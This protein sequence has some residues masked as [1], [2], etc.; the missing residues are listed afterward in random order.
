MSN[1]KWTST[2]N[3]E[4]EDWSGYVGV[5]KRH[6]YDGYCTSFSCYGNNVGRGVIKAREDGPYKCPDCGYA[7]VY[8]KRKMSKAVVD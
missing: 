1:H 2:F 5:A 7:L 3:K 4:M 6:T 8:R